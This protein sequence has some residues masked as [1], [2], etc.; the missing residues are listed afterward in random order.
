[1]K[2]EGGQIAFTY[3]YRK[4]NKNKTPFFQ[5]LV[6]RKSWTWMESAYPTPDGANR[7]KEQDED[8]RQMGK[9]KR[10]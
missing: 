1:M 2:Q 6:S 4:Q 8:F 7:R 9:R 3:I 10:Y 5:Q